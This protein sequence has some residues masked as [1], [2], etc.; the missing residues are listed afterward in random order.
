M[1]T[2]QERVLAVSAYGF[3]PI[4]FLAYVD[5]NVVRIEEVQDL[6]SYPDARILVIFTAQETH[7]RMAEQ[8]NVETWQSESI[9]QSGFVV[10][11]RRPNPPLK[12]D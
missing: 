8:L 6:S 12:S 5:R 11:K 7:R 1:T 2:P 4:T 3:V 9:D 10:Y